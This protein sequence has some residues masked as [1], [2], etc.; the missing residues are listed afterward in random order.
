MASQREPIAS[1][2][3]RRPIRRD[4]KGRIVESDGLGKSL[5]QDVGKNAKT[6]V[7]PVQGDRADRKRG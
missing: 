5:S 7:K 4:A 6:I 2:G 1:R 3:D